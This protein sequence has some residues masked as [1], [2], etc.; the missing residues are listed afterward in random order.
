MSD[1]YCQRLS[2]ANPSSDTEEKYHDAVVA[3]I[4]DASDYMI[5]DINL[6]LHDSASDPSPHGIRSLTGELNLMIARQHLR[7]QGLGQE[8]LKLFISYVLENIESVIQEFKGHSSQECQLESF[9]AKIDHRNITSIKLF[10][11]FGFVRS[12]EEPNYF[13]ELDFTL[14]VN[15]AREMIQSQKALLKTRVIDYKESKEHGVNS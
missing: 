1:R 9:Q 15:R 8:V 4:D 12:R 3:G 5:G 10:E 7:G 13:G 2:G 6:F 11:R 14:T